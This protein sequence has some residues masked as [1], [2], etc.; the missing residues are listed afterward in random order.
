MI[1]DWRVLK[2][3]TISSARRGRLVTGHGIIQT[4]FFMPIATKG[5]VKSLS[6][7]DMSALGAQIVLANTYHLYLR[8]GLEVLRRVGGL[9]NFMNWSGPIL[10]DSGGFQVFSLAASVQR[11]GVNKT[12]QAVKVDRKISQRGVEFRSFWDGSK[13]LFTPAKVLHIQKIIGSDIAM[14]LDECVGNP[15][16][17][18]QAEQ[19]LRRTTQW[20][21]QSLAA[22]AKYLDSAQLLF[23]IVQGSTYQDLRLTS[24]QELIALQGSGKK[25][26]DGFAIGGL[27]VGESNKQMYQVLD[28]T[29]PALPSD[30]PRYLMGVGYPDNIIEA[31]RRG[32]D[33]FDCVIPTREARHGRLYKWLYSDIAS[34]IKAIV[35][36]KQFYTTIN[37]N[38]ASFAQSSV[39]LRPNFSASWL[40]NYSLAYW[41]HLFKVG[42]PLALRLA[43]WNNVAFYLQLMAL[44]RRA[45]KEDRL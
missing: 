7:D 27:A 11:V 18:E 6:G 14:V 39:I 19:A 22:R 5:T 17:R 29:V 37:I 8:P 12:G 31:V 24:A 13:H 9:H 1:G 36:G 32:V 3:S 28:Y 43:T 38:N 2:K 4:P 30:K 26:W 44:L 21:G 10:T 25:V 20:A 15:A 40:D 42:E 16:T 45:I 41:H 34:T 23:A 33:M 35:G